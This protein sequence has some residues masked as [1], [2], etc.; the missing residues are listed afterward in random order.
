[1]FAS[2]VSTESGVLATMAEPGGSPSRLK[3]WE[4]RTWDRAS[5]STFYWIANLKSLWDSWIKRSQLTN[6]TEKESQIQ[7][8]TFIDISQCKEVAYW[9]FPIVP[10]IHSLYVRPSAFTTPCWLSSNYPRATAISNWDQ[11]LVR[12]PDYDT[13]WVYQNSLS[14]MNFF[15][16]PCVPLPRTYIS[17]G[18]L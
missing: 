9:V 1:M 18:N 12:T 11:S 8:D 4:P 17:R 10:G 2:H 15:D 5:S 3:P 13:Q 14:V 6:L 16:A 7:M